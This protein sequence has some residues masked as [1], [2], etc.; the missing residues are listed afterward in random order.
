MLSSTRNQNGGAPVVEIVLLAAVLALAAFAGYNYYHSR[1]AANSAVAP[2]PHKT[3]VS[4]S[5]SPATVSQ[6]ST[7]LKTNYRNPNGSAPLSGVKITL[8]HLEG[9]YA[10]V[11][12]STP[13]TGPGGE[14]LW[15]KQTQSGWSIVWRGQNESPSQATNLGVPADFTQSCT[16]STVL[17]SF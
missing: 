14:E 16:A 4:P 9:S 11:G 3:A 8:C 1:Q 7:Y 2:V 12:V 15:L 17:A 10:D 13:T 6:L 5:S